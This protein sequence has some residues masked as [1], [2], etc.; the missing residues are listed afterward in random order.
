MPYLGEIAALLTSLA[1]SA[2]ST[3]FTIGGRQV[4]P[5]ILN[6]IRLALA[7]VFII[8]AHWVLL[9]Q[10][11][12]LDAGPER[13]LWLGLS[14]LIGLVVG[15]AFL[16]Q[17]FLWI[18]T[19][20]SMLMMSLAP[21][22]AALIAWL[23][24]G[25]TLTPL[26][27]FG[28]LLTISGVALV[29]MEHN[30]AKNNPNRDYARGIIFGL[31]AAIGQALGLVLAKNGMSGDFSPLSGN[32]IRMITAAVAM[33]GL[34]AFQGQV[35]V[36][37]RRLAANRRAALIL[38]AGSFTGPFVGVSLSLLAIQHAPVGIASTLMSLS[39]IFLLPISYVVFKERFGWQVILGTLVTMIGVAILFL[40]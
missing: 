26:Q 25:E 23:F 6:R 12:P 5:V 39:P 28:I 9:G 2:T 13:W 31:G 27:V 1:W 17:A 4:G 14:G 15:D 3:M 22:I 11:F 32:F 33:W 30:G 24:L 34:A 8:I 10:P 29:I 37:L 16:Y 35:G 21:V 20:L 7:V 36:T 18:G 19:R 38:L 40:V